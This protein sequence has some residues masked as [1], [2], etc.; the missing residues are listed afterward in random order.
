[1]NKLKLAI[2]SGH[3]TDGELLHS[4]LNQL[5]SFQI[6][7]MVST[8]QF[9]ELSEMVNSF[10]EEWMD[11]P[12]SFFQTIQDFLKALDFVVYEDFTIDFSLWYFYEAPEQKYE[13]TVATHPLFTAP[14]L[15]AT[16]EVYNCLLTIDEAES[17]LAK[18]I[19]FAR[20]RNMPVPVSNKVPFIVTSGLEVGSDL[21]YSGVG[22]E[23]A[24]YTAIQL[25]QESILNLAG[26]EHVLCLRR[27]S[28]ELKP[29]LK[30]ALS[31][32]VYLTNCTLGKLADLL[33]RPDT[34]SEFTE[35]FTQN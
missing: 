12:V 11:E 19:Q 16:G 24:V 27:L 5:K 3:I 33:D 13:A 25:I 31:K 21:T 15:T 20:D 34:W 8:Q 17:Y 23:V 14:K 32:E 9:A 30:S 6:C 26:K 28:S 1:M 2:E 22:T 10:Q 7:Q 4:Q 18:A 29:R 35:K